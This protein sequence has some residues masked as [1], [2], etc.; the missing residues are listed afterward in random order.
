[1]LPYEPHEVRLPPDKIHR[2]PEKL[3][4]HFRFGG[5]LCIDPAQPKSRSA[6]AKQKMLYGS[7]DLDMDSY[8][9]PVVS[10]MKARELAGNTNL[11]GTP[12]FHSPPGTPIPERCEVVYDGSKVDTIGN[13][14]Q[15]HK[16]KLQAL[17][18]HNAVFLKYDPCSKVELKPQT[19]RCAKAQ[20]LR[21]NDIFATFKKPGRDRIC[22]ELE[23][24]YDMKERNGNWS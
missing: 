17:D 20:E 24:Y 6:W 23:Q 18:G 7:M 15:V 3:L 2:N 4:S 13:A 8:P 19:L 14:R 12:P 21:G 10:D 9:K 5:P 22:D 11:F 16:T 1:M